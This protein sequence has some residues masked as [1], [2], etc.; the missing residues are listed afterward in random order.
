MR[1]IIFGFALIFTVHANTQHDDLAGKYDFWIGHWNVT[2]DEG[3]GKVG[4]G[5]N[6]IESTTGGKVIRENFKI[7]KGQSKGFKG[8]SISVFNGSSGTW[9]Q[10]WAD[11]N[12]GYFD[13][14]GGSDEKGNPT[15]INAVRQTDTSAVVQRMVFRNIREDAFTWDWEGSKDGGKTWTLNWQINY[16]KMKPESNSALPDDFLP[17]LGT[18]KCKSQRR[19]KDGDWQEAIDASWTF[20]LIME[21]RG[22]QDE[23]ALANGNSGGS[24]RQYSHDDK[25]WYVHYYSSLSPTPN[26][27]SWEGE[28]KE[29]GNIVLYSPQKSTEGQDGFLKLTFHNISE[30]GYDWIGEWVDE[31]ED[32][33]NAFWKISCTRD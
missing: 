17:M 2:W 32:T 13:F 18:C 12:G 8:T 7:T 11:S 26:L 5:I 31:N 29:N 9:K 19:N 1:F 21:G 6:I 24:I 25:K 28:M 15:F 10:A 22:I 33:K 27:Q 4:K 20:K 16:S 23:F 3:E 30:K 14:T